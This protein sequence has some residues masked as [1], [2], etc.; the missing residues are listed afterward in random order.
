M[1]ISLIIFKFSIITTENIIIIQ[2]NNNK[3]FE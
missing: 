2:L 3:T 1:H